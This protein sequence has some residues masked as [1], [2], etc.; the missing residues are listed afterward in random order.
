MVEGGIP[1]PGT[2]VVVGIDRLTTQPARPAVSLI[3]GEAACIRNLPPLAL[4]RRLAGGADTVA[5]REHVAAR[6]TGARRCCQSSPVP[7]EA[8]VR[9]PPHNSQVC[10]LGSTGTYR[11]RCLALSLRQS[12]QNLAYG[13]ADSNGA[14]QSQQVR[15]CIA[16]PS[17]EQTHQRHPCWKS[18]MPL[19][20]DYF[21]GVTQRGRIS[22]SDL[23]VYD[24]TGTLAGV[25]RPRS[26]ASMPVSRTYGSVFVSRAVLSAKGPRACAIR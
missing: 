22:F 13:T 8:A 23:Y 10:G 18:W 24:V 20:V 16:A 15:W 4:T 17:S 11:R 25:A 1:P 7:F 6:W 19:V 9:T 2:W 26:A 5:L 21:F 14:P 12:T 3:D